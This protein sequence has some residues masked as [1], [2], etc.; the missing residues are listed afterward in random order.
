MFNF[1]RITLFCL[2]KR[3]S[4]TKRT[5]FSKHFGGHD[6]F[7]PPGYAYA[8]APS[9]MF[10]VRHW[11]DSRSLCFVHQSL[12]LMCVW[13][14]FQTEE[15]LFHLLGITYYVTHHRLLHAVTKHFNPF[16]IQRGLSPWTD[17]GS[18]GP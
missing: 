16:R 10:C 14:S 12:T 17:V 3:L 15:A 18:A 9:E 8:L 13:L 2:E 5:I 11:L 6:P 1:R 7:G 4:K